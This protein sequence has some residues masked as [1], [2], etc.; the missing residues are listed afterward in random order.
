MIRDTGSSWV[1]FAGVGLVAAV[2]G[3]VFFLRG[4]LETRRPEQQSAIAEAVAPEEVV[5]ARLWQDPL[6]AIQ[7]HWD[8]VEAVAGKSRA[9]GSDDTGGGVVSDLRRHGLPTIHDMRERLSRREEGDTAPNE[10][11][12]AQSASRRL[13]LVI[14]LASEPYAEDSENRR[15]RRHAVVSALTENDYVP[16]HA[17]RL[18]YFT[19]PCFEDTCV[20][21][22]E[23]GTWV[24]TGQK[25]RIGFEVFKG[26]LETAGDSPWQS[27]HVLWLNA[28][29]FRNCSPYR[30]SALVAYLDRSPPRRVAARTVLVG[31]TTSGAL[32]GLEPPESEGACLGEVRH[33]WLEVQKSR[34]GAAARPQ[35]QPSSGDIERWIKARRENL[36]ILSPGATAPLE[37]LFREAN[38]LQRGCLKARNVD[39]AWR[40]DICLGEHLKIESFDSVVARDDVVLG[41][42][43]EE[44]RFR[45]ASRPLIAIVS[46]QDSA[47]G[48]LLDDV[49][50]ALVD[51][52]REEG[53]RR[54]ME[55]FEVAEYGYLAGVDGEMPP[56]IA[57]LTRRGESEDDRSG[58]PGSRG[59]NSIISWRHVEQAFGAQQLDYVRRLADQIVRD[60]AAPGGQPDDAASQDGRDSGS[61]GFRQKDRD[62]VVGVLGTDVYDKLLIIQ[63]LRDRLPTAT[64]FTTDLDARLTHPDVFPWTRN[65]IVG[66][67]YGLSVRDLNGAPF[68]DS[69][70]T[71]TFRAVT[72]A[73]QEQLPAGGIAPPPLLFEIGRNGAVPIT[74]YRTARP[75]ENADTSTTGSRPDDEASHPSAK[76]WS[77]RRVGEWLVVLAPLLL[78]VGFAWATRR[79]LPE[80][81]ADLRRRARWR[82]TLVGA[83]TIVLAGLAGLLPDGY[84][85]G[86]FLEGVNSFPTLVLY[87]TTLVYAYAAVV[88]GAA[89]IEQAKKAFQDDDWKLPSCPP[90]PSRESKKLAGH[91]PLWLSSWKQDVPRTSTEMPKKEAG[92]CWGLYLMYGARNERIK[93]LSLLILPTLFV[94]V[95][96]VFF[97]SPQAPLLTRSYP[98]L[99]KWVGVLTTVGVVGAVFFCDDVLRLG[100]ALIR[101][102]GRHEVVGWPKEEPGDHVGQHWRTMRFLEL[103]TDSVMPVAALPFVLL[104]LLIFAR[105][106][107]FEGWVWTGQIL[108]LFAGLV[109][110][111]AMRALLFQLEAVRAKNAIVWCLDRLRLERVGKKDETEV[112]IQV[113]IVKERIEGIRRGAFGPWIRHPIVQSLLLPSLA[114]GL[115]VLLESTL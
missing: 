33:W 42:I 10:R 31:P 1:G 61:R 53:G 11:D 100:R 91:A 34:P 17:A 44:I 43:L 3:S 12:E 84:E 107:L 82:V 5:L 85:P 26:A 76:E 108:L 70:Q 24:R 40:A 55:G 4:P 65:L 50:Q 6:H 56:L 66:S 83:L 21:S 77:A 35:E 38:E 98:N 16:E 22:S 45:G 25:M 109:V 13:L 74:Q 20:G 15:R 72:L 62:V 94:V 103:Y 106:T 112:T 92:R 23:A 52:S 69:Y 58:G 97:V 81:A 54:A 28:D 90:P 60:L 36:R 79:A 93:R 95:A 86:Q 87:L 113:E 57:E 102:I 80:K 101:E 63:A 30:V 67:S 110:Y 7:T 48:R 37:L 68:R 64:F 18:G 49:V 41:T 111:V 8:G 105:S 46:E 88:I 32:R 104:A 2:V 19:A 115:V 14:P 75:R 27:I 71:A 9:L 29:D 47:Y 114:Y 89:R 96:V 51:E 73:L 39:D 59:R 99:V 78:L